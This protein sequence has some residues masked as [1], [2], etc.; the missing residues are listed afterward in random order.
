MLRFRTLPARLKPKMSSQSSSLLQS[1]T[2]QPIWASGTAIAILLT[3]LAIIPA[4]AQHLDPL[5][6]LPVSTQTTLRDGKVIVNGI[7]GQYTG[8]VLVKAPM[9]TVWA[10]LTDYN[11]FKTFMP[12]VESSKLLSSQGNQR[13]FEQVNVAQ[14]LTFKFQSRLRIAATE[15]YPKQIVFKAIDGDI[16][17]LEGRWKLNSVVAENNNQVLI[18]HNVKVEPGSGNR[19]L[20]LR[21]YKTG[22]ES[23]LVSIKQE[24]ERRVRRN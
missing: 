2:R 11:N 6:Q 22:L 17:S 20:Y 13:I 9:T 10:V 8:R 16:K 4:I 1:W 3:S 21:L 19:D 14:I 23:T 7:N 5:A 24:V 12:N 15:S 18:T